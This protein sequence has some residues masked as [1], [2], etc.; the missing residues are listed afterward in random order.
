V[1]VTDQS[2]RYITGMQKSDFSVYVDGV[3]RPVQLLRRDLDTTHF[4]C[5][6]AWSA[7]RRSPVLHRWPSPMHA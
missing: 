6:K 2:G 3:Q 5:P 4:S 1:T 7:V